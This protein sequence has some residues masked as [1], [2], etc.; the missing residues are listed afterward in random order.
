MPQSTI[1]LLF[2]VA[3]LCWSLGPLRAEPLLK[4]S[5]EGRV[6]DPSGAA[7]AGARVTAVGSTSAFASAGTDQKG[8]FSLS[9]PPGAYTLTV[10]ADGF[11]DA[12]RSV[13]VTQ[14]PSS[15]S[16]NRVASRRA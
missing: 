9:L 13:S 10:A 8:E 14:E 11:T 5:V 12:V 15:A 7:I 1:R 6:L 2:S 4:G 3:V 16:C